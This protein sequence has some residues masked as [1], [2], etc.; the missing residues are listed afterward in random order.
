[1]DDWSVGKLKGNEKTQKILRKKED[2]NTKSLS[3]SLK[4]SF[5]LAQCCP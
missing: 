2:E 1:M 5:L 4:Y 3:L